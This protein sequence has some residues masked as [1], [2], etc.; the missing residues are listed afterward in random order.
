MPDDKRNPLTIHEGYQPRP[1]PRGRACD[2]YQ[3]T[4]KGSLSKDG[5]EQARP[6]PPRGGSGVPGTAPVKK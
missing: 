5:K 1:S 4:A 2:G 6:Q 3:P